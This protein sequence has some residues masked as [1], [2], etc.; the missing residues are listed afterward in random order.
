MAADQNKPGAF[1]LW[2]GVDSL[3]LLADMINSIQTILGSIS[4]CKEYKC[5]MEC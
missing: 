3:S 4:L 5:I 1:H 2:I